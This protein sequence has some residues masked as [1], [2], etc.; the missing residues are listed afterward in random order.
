VLVQGSNGAVLARSDASITVTRD[1]AGGFYFVNFGSSVLNKM[2]VAT[3]NRTGGGQTG[4]VTAGACGGSGAGANTCA[5]SNNSST[6]LVET[7]TS[8][9]AG[10][11]RNFF[12]AVI[13]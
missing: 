9:G 12:L 10:A 11:D 1:G 2:I 6:V 8:A 4:E 3:P 7:T 13:P 5:Q